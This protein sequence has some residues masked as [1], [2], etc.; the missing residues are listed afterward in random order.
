MSTKKREDLSEKIKTALDKGV[1][2]LIAETK[3]TNSYLVTS[4]KKGNVK[5][6]LAKDL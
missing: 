3:A 1:K 2:K 4:D 5:K 6:I